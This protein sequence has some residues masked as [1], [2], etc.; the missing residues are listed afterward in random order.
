MLACFHYKPATLVVGSVDSL[1]TFLAFVLRILYYLRSEISICF[2]V[3]L[4]SQNDKN[5]L[6]K[7]QMF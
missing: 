5:A 2:S 1:P 6:L 7:E 4:Y 3:L